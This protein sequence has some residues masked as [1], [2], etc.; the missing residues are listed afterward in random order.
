MYEKKQQGYEKLAKVQL[1]SIPWDAFIPSSDLVF[2]TTM[3][4]NYN[5]RRIYMDEGS[6][7]DIMYENCFNKLPEHARRTLKPPTMS[8]IGFLGD[9]SYPEG[10]IDLE[11]TV[12]THPLLRIVTLEFHFVKSTSNYNFLLGRTT[13]QNLNIEVS[14]IRSIVEFLTI[15]GI[16]IVKSDYPG[17][18]AS[19]AALVEK[20]RRKEI[21]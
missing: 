8:M 15:E 12:E 10:V 20:T 18:D 21:H 5:V 4:D 6:S 14:T 2:I 1:R 9:R 3:I 7:F 11:L 13:M 16:T 17:R 19:L